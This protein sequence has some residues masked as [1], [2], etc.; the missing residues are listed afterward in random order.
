MRCRHAS[1]ALAL[2][3]LAA[4]A[5][6]CARHGE[7]PDDVVHDL[8]AT[9]RHQEVS[10]APD[11]SQLAAL[12]PF[13][14]ADLQELLLEARELR[15]AEQRRAPD[16]KPP[17]VE[18]DLFTS[19]FEGHTRSR[20]LA[21]SVMPDSSTRVTV[22][23]T[24][25]AVSP[26]VE[27]LDVVVTRREGDRMVVADVEYGGDWP[28]ANHGTLV[29]QLEAGLRSGNE[30]GVVVT[31]AGGRTLIL[32]DDTTQGD[33]YVRHT[34][35]GRVRGTPFHLVHQAFIEGQ[36][37]LLVHD[38]TGTTIRIDAPPIVSP[39]RQRFLTASMDLEAAFDPTRLAVWR[40]EGDTAYTEWAIEPDEWGPSDARWRGDDTV[41][42]T[43][44]VRTGE[45]GLTRPL[46][47]RVART[48]DAWRLLAPRS[49]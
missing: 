36:G 49:P 22:Q 2:T 48:G 41:T 15:D 18:G 29:R 8:Y 38:T 25:D 24:Y 27:W 26:A 7:R 12:S 40:I 19:S 11:A 35:R 28:F 31:L 39:D 30:A 33:T 14:S 6:A 9:L 42:F 32:A 23:F 21:D 37:Y 46:A 16:Q 43:A 1:V 17:F 44:N 13:L 5:P 45:A 10:G 34:Y 4:V 3:G 20:I 47:G